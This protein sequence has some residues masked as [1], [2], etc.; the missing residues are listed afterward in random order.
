MTP[1]AK[2]RPLSTFNFI[3]QVGTI[4]NIFIIK[5]Y[6]KLTQAFNT[7]QKV[8]LVVNAIKFSYC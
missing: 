4:S 6:D 5:H 7:F 2:F 1:P 3:A 8:S